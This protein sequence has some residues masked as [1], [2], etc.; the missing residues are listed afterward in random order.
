M[1]VD[2]PTVAEVVV[3]PDSLEQLLAAHH[4]AGIVGQLAEQA[5]FSLGQ[6]QFVSA[7]G[8]DSFVGIDVEVPDCARQAAAVHC[9]ASPQQG[10]DAGGQFLWRE[11][12]REV[13]VS[14][15]F[16]SGHDVMGVVA[17]SHHD[18]RHMADAA[19]GAAQFEPVET[20][21]HDVDQ[22]DIGALRREPLKRFLAGLCF[23]DLPAFV[24]QRESQRRADSL[25][26]FNCE[27]V[28]GQCRTALSSECPAARRR[29]GPVPSGRSFTEAWSAHSLMERSTSAASA[30]TPA[31]A[32]SAPTTVPPSAGPTHLG[33][34]CRAP[35]A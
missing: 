25:V 5:E 30:A 10:P 27:N 4:L 11:G 20:G 22:H 35:V 23:A 34:H 1:H 2:E 7:L 17:S 13:V 15:G 21:K 12:F 6:V 24:F 29:P 28:G 31:A 26:V 3:A 18:D 8:H 9:P 14:S 19:D 16:E 33:L 32:A